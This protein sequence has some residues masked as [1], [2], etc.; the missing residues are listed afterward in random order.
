[1]N[2]KERESGK[3]GNK[4]EEERQIQSYRLCRCLKNFIFSVTWQHQLAFYFPLCCLL[5]SSLHI[6]MIPRL[7]M[8]L[9]RREKK[10]K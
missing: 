1:M 10:K 6:F 8:N 7:L 4:K 2:A 9:K 5:A 3:E